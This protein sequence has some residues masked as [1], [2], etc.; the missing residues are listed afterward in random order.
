MFSKY[1]HYFSAII[2]WGGWF[3]LFSS[4]LLFQSCAKSDEAKSTSSSSSSSSDT[5]NSSND[6]TSP[7]GTN[8]TPVAKDITTS[9]YMD[10]GGTIQL[11]G[12][13][14]DNDALSYS[15]VIQPSNGKLGNP[16]SSGKV[17]YTPTTGY[18]GSDSFKYRVS[19]GKAESETATV[20]IDVVLD[21]TPPNITNAYEED[22]DSIVITWTPISG[23]DGYRLYRASS[24][25]GPFTNPY[26]DNLTG[27]SYTDDNLSA[28]TS[29]HYQLSALRKG[30][31]SNRSAT[32]SI[33]TSYPLNK[34]FTFS[35]G[36]PSSWSST[37]TGWKGITGR[38]G[39]GIGFEGSS[40]GSLITHS[41]EIPSSGSTIKFYQRIRKPLNYSIGITTHRNSSW[42]NLK[43]ENLTSTQNETKSTSKTTYTYQSSTIYFS[44]PNDTSAINYSVSGFPSS[45]S[46]SWK[47]CY[48][49]IGGMNHDVTSSSA[50]GTVSSSLWNPGSSLSLYIYDEGTSRYSTKTYS[51]TLSYA[52]GH[53]LSSW[54]QLELDSSS[55]DGQT[56]KLRFRVISSSSNSQWHIDDLSISPKPPSA[57]S[58]S[59]TSSGVDSLTLAWNHTN[60]EKYEL[61][62]STSSNGSYKTI[63]DNLS[64]T[65]Y[66]DTGLTANTTYYYRI[67]GIV[68]TLQGSFSSI[69]SK[70]TDSIGTASLS[71][72]PNGGTK[73]DLSWS[74]ATNAL[75][76]EL[77]RSTS[78][79][80]TF[81]V[82]SDNLSSTS[83]TDSGLNPSTNYY[84]RIRGLVNSQKGNFSSESSTTTGPEA[85]SG[86]SGS[87]L[88]KNSILVTW[89]LVSGVTQYSVYRSEADNGTFNLVKSN[90]SSLSFQDSSLTCST[91]YYYQ[92]KGVKDDVE[93]D[94]SQTISVS[95][96]AEIP[97]SPSKP[98]VSNK[99]NGSSIGVS[100][101]SV[102]C[103]SNYII[104]R[105]TSSSS[106]F[107]KIGETASTS[108]ID[109]ATSTGTTYYYRVSG[110]SSAGVGNQSSTSSGIL[111]APAA[112]ANLSA[113]VPESGGSSK[114]TL[115]WSAASSATSYS[116]YRSTS[117][118]GT[119]SSSGTTSSTSYTVTGLSA[120]TTYFFKVAASNSGGT[121][122]KSS[123]QSTTTLRSAPSSF[124]ASGISSSEIQLTW[125][126]Y[127]N[128]NAYKIYRGGSLISTVTGGTTYQD[129]ALTTATSYNYTLTAIV[130][131]T[132]TD[133][134]SA[135]GNT[136]VAT[137]EGFTANVQ[138]SSS[139]TL[140]WN[141]VSNATSYK[142]YKDG[143]LITSSSSTSY[144]VSSLSANTSYRFKVKA[145]SSTYGESK[146]SK[147]ENVTTLL[148]TPSVTV[149]NPSDSSVLLQWNLV[150][151]ASSYKVYRDT[152]SSLN[153]SSA[154]SSTNGTSFS[155]N[156]GSSTYYYR[157]AAFTSGGVQGE[158]STAQISKFLGG[159]W[160]FTNAGSTGRYGPT[161]S[162][163][164][165]AYSGTDLDGQV[166]I[167]TRGVQEWKVPAT[168]SY[169]IEIWG[170]SGGGN[171][172]NR[173]RGVKL[174]GDFS[175][176]EGEKLK[177]LVGQEGGYHTSGGGGGGTFVVKS[178]DTKLI[179]A[180]GGGGQY[181]SSSLK[182][183][184]D[185]ST[186][187][188]GRSSGCKS[189]GSSGQ[190]GSGCNSSGASGGGGFSGSGSNGS[191]G[192]G[193]SS[194]LSG[195]IGGNYGSSSQA[196]G[197]FGGGAGTHGNTG[198]GGGG[199]GYSG[200]A[201][202]W[203]NNSTGNGGGGGSFNSGSNKSSSVLDS[204]GHGKVIITYQ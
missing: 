93:S 57:P 51:V 3:I 187:E 50:S 6:D 64:G 154:Y 39:Q 162:Q 90:L 106:G 155:E 153:C 139:V 54:E 174:K 200:G 131:G 19:D 185:A 199:G 14:G 172:S 126:L 114:V 107:S 95:T 4:I 128:A 31:E 176:S 102:E 189:G 188:S 147:E 166:T 52:L 117:L 116:V 96:V 94:P 53:V 127:S 160:T 186:S 2:Y 24:S 179:I 138:S 59:V 80:G 168:G 17:T 137:P 8:C 1:G 35:N 34:S 182:Y 58:L 30:Y 125:N 92:I 86:G 193:G 110:S 134:A 41:F 16:D 61:Q 70:K 196:V 83:Y 11:S 115:S 100:W 104:Y 146:E 133:Q 23:A 148:A 108:Y 201:G 98:S 13:D 203:H 63:S 71:V 103:G 145:Y 135:T 29:Y 149:T 130:S 152:S 60:A 10:A 79:G 43:T 192:T 120:N 27:S 183:N 99:A 143:S 159:P 158:C 85:P 74:A 72:S 122:A 47:D 164:N 20:T 165:S 46:Y 178:D 101:N 119:Y 62:R 194:F 97:P 173:G 144:T 36:L 88:N 175:L 82:I 157:V 77:Q 167:N 7:C 40:S 129:S 75:L 38:S 89:N 121:G 197:G 141:S 161:Q 49:T 33:T 202:G 18:L 177:I 180:G 190:G 91:T 132:E 150:S 42:T 28:E 84:Y 76:Y 55:F 87:G 113:S 136:T 123:G 151:G 111:T 109:N 12:S 156:I 45:C 170:A 171:S 195:G 140:S 32:K 124:T 56:V 48:I 5:D 163:V 204:F 37:S 69:L 44:V 105:S 181:T 184:S 198:G 112:P 9:V 142:I 65:S 73:V 15:I 78:S 81:T 21:T 66:K 22:S 191:Y 25:S 169:S 118:N 67:R 68:K 26:K